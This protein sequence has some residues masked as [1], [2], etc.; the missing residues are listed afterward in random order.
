MKQ[1]TQATWGEI[2]A[3]VGDGNIRPAMTADEVD[4]VAPV[5]VVEPGAAEDLAMVLACANRTGL[6]VIPRGGGTKLDW[7]NPPRHADLV[8]STARL[9]RVLEHAW[10]DMTATV[11]AGCTVAQF[12][13]TLAEHGQRLAL[14]PLWPDRAT[15]GGILATNDS[16]ALRTRYGSLRD[17]IIGITLALPDGTLAKSGG[18]VVKNVAGYDLPKLATGSFG[19]LGV[20]TEAVFRLHPLPHDTRSLGFTASSVETLCQLRDAIQDSRLAYTCLQLR[21]YSAGQPSLDVLFEGTRAGLDAQERQLLQLAAKAIRSHSSEGWSARE[22]LWQGG[23]RK[24]VAKLS[25]LPTDLSGFCTALREAATEQGVMWEVTAHAIGVAQLRL[26]AVTEDA[27]LAVLQR[28]RSHAESL[29]GTL[30][31]LRC[32]H[33]TKSR[34]DVWGHP[35]DSFPLFRRVKEQLDPGG[36]LNPGR[37]VGGI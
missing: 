30:V 17:L 25:L 14:D 13:R 34:F 15:V 8:L 6:T 35:G 18:K 9:G 28:L 32:S 23:G 19:T 5:A 29:G 4:G 37:F 11:Q 1:Q 12:Q 36:I 16:G 31:V 10:G 2:T 26:E 22:A 33:E 24:A 21:A 20:I 27:L 3:I 7:G